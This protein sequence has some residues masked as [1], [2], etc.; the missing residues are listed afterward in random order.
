MRVELCQFNGEMRSVESCDAGFH[1]YP[2]AR[3]P[4]RGEIEAAVRTLIAATGDDP[5][6]EGL[7]DTPSRVVRAYEEWFAGYRIDPETLLERTFEETE[8]WGY[9]HQGPHGTTMCWPTDVSRPF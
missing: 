3:K 1:P 5:T 7:L 4:S 9:R 2:A 6:R 8:G